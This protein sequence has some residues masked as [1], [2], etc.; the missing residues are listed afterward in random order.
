MGRVGCIMNWYKRKSEAHFSDSSL[1]MND[2]NYCVFSEND[3][4]TT[5][6]FDIL[7]K[8]HW[9]NIVLLVDVDQKLM[10][11]GTYWSWIT[12]WVGNRKMFLLVSF[13][14]LLVNGWWIDG[15]GLIGGYLSGI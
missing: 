3:F 5:T 2:D 1:I 10:W 13:E 12:S 8:K 7:T 4:T 6:F 9:W 11:I 14:K 15:W